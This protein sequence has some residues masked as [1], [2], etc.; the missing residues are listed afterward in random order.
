[1]ALGSLSGGTVEESCPARGWFPNG[2]PSDVSRAPSPTRPGVTIRGAG[3]VFAAGN[4]YFATVR[5]IPRSA[6]VTNVLG[7][8]HVSTVAGDPQRNLD[9]FAGLLGLRLVKRTVNFDDPET[10]HLY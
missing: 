9:F 1:M 2:V 10:Y 5:S 8:H 4:G 7:I 6:P 3:S